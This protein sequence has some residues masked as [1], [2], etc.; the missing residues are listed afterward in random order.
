MVPYDGTRKLTEM[1]DET[2]DCFRLVRPWEG[3]DGDDAP[4]VGD[5]MRR[6]DMVGYGTDV[7]HRRVVDG[8]AQAG[9]DTRN[10][11]DCSK[12]SWRVPEKFLGW[13]WE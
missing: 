3:E 13:E 9:T 4:R 12:Q 8:I 10:V 1:D 11:R 6:T 7:D 2:E 5:N